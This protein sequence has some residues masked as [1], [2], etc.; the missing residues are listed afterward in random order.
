[1]YPPENKLILQQT[2]IPNKQAFNACQAATLSPLFFLSPAILSRAALYTCGA[3][4]ALSY[5]GATAR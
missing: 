1:M 3:V 4:G 5:V 2:E